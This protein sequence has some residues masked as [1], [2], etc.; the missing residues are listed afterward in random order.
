LRSS[1]RAPP[2]RPRP[3]AETATRTGAS[4]QRSR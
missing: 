2:A 4:A 3:L 1:S